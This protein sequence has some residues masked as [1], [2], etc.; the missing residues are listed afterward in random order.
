[1]PI[2]SIFLFIDS[3]INYQV[4]I[5]RKVFSVGSLLFENKL[6]NLLPLLL[7]IIIRMLLENPA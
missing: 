2:I 1:M 7:Y 6:V 4:K 3:G 5:R